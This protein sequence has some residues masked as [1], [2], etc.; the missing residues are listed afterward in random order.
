M[1]VVIIG[2]L[3]DVYNVV[4]IVSVQI[5]LDQCRLKGATYPSRPPLRLQ[6]HHSLAD[7]F[8]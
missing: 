5:V 8:A 1:I 3:E 4:K 2:F 7:N 6:H